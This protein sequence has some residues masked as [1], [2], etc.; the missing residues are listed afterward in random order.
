MRNEKFA[1]NTKA[2]RALLNDH[3]QINTDHPAFLNMQTLSGAK[4]PAT[5]TAV[6]RVE[7]YKECHRLADAFYRLTGSR[8]VIGQVMRFGEMLLAKSEA[9]ALQVNQ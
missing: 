3:G 8:Q 6:E 7:I 2:Y 9:K 1:N 5:P 4:S